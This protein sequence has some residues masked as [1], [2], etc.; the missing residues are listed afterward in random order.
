MGASIHTPRSGR[1]GLATSAC[2]WIRTTTS[3]R[4]GLRLGIL[5]AVVVF[6]RW[7]RR[8]SLAHPLMLTTRSSRK[9]QSRVLVM[10]QFFASLSRSIGPSQTRS[11]AFE[12]C[13]LLEK[14]QIVTAALQT[15][16]IMVCTEGFLQSIG[17]LCLAVHLAGTIH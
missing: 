11:M 8:T 17:Y 4:T 10:A 9:R 7:F 16:V 12:S 6:V 3:H 13:G 5:L 1:S 2:A 15:S 14:F